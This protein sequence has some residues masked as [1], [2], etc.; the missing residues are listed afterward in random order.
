MQTIIKKEK[1]F[2]TLKLIFSSLLMARKFIIYEA[3]SYSHILDRP[4]ENTD[5]DKCT[6][7]FCLRKKVIK[8]GTLYLYLE[9]Q[10]KESL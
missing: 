4:S 10:N 6:S 1:S 8:I 7:L 2:V 9:C 5:R 3:L